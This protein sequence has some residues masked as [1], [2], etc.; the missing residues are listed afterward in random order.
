M[1]MNATDFLVANN[2]QVLEHVIRRA[3]DTNCYGPLERASTYGMFTWVHPVVFRPVNNIGWAPCIGYSDFLARV[4][5]PFRIRFQTDVTKV[6]RTDSSV[7]ITANGKTETFDWVILTNK[8]TNGGG[9]IVDLRSDE[10]ALFS[11]L[12]TTHFRTTLVDSP[13]GTWI[14]Q[15][16]FVLVS[17]EALRPFWTPAPDIWT[18]GCYNQ[19][20]LRTPGDTSLTDSRVCAQYFYNGRDPTPAERTTE[21]NNYLIAMG[22]STI[23]SAN[24]TEVAFWESRDY[25]QRNQPKLAEGYLWD[26]WEL[27]GKYRSWYVGSAVT[28]IETIVDMFD[29]SKQLVDTMVPHEPAP[30]APEIPCP[31]AASSVSF[32][33]WLTLLL[34]FILKFY[35]I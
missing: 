24:W 12:Y 21:L 11:D 28:G 2:L 7:S 22:L 4:A 25:W 14:G 19:F 17:Q 33:F 31:S 9:A 18:Y 30:A 1:A 5:L 34:A 13:G 15:P 29:Y 32:I 6:V 16:G 35:V 8:W 27:Q 10:L 3:M 26:A 20:V 23:T